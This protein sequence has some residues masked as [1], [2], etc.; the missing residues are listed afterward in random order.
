M[1]IEE[2]EYC[3]RESEF[4]VLIDGNYIRLCRDCVDKDKMVI[5]KKP[6]KIQIN[7]SY[8]RP[9]VKQILTRM[10]G[11][12]PKEKIRTNNSQAHDLNSLRKPKSIDPPVLKPTQERKINSGKVAFNKEDL[13]KEE[14]LDI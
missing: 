5:I 4:D 12:P 10:S 7:D 6:D 1:T 8:K 14:F 13:E 3:G 11:I 2:C 9:T